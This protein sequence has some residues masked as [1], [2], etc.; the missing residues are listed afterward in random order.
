MVV[1]F[2]RSAVAST[3]RIQVN[4]ARCVSRSI[5]RRVREIVECSGGGSSRPRPRN[6]RSASESAVR[7]AMPRSESMPSKYLISSSRKVRARR[8]ARATHCRGVEW[9]ALRLN[10]RVERVGVED[11][12]QPPGRRD[13]RP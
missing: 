6:P 1:P 11:L 12:I 9:G 5:K 2:T 7:H 10:K 8:Q 3:C 13:A 4:T